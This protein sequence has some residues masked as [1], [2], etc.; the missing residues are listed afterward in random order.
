MDKKPQNKSQ[1]AKNIPSEN[2]S[3]ENPSAENRTFGH[4]KRKLW[5]K[6]KSLGRTEV[7]LM[8]KASSNFTATCSAGQT[9]LCGGDGSIF[10]SHLTTQHPAPHSSLQVL[11][12]SSGKRGEPV[13]FSSA[14]IKQDYTRRSPMH[15][16]LFHPAFGPPAEL[17]QWVLQ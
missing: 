16:P 11:G 9:V 12:L 5:L 2:K 13:L 4:G 1:E 3:H 17:N 6:V 14:M 8:R 7:Q 10:F 15:T